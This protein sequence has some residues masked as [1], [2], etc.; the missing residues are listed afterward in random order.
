MPNRSKG[1]EETKS[2]P[3]AL[4]VGNWAVGH[5][6]IRTMLEMGKCAQVTKEMQRYCI[7][8]V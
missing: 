8:V 2:D 3:L 4:Q 5:W 7:Q 6:K 1:G